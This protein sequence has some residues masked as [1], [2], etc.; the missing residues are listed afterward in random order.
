VSHR[1]KNPR[2]N[3]VEAV[4]ASKSDEWGDATRQ[5]VRSDANRIL[6]ALVS[7]IGIQGVVD[8]MDRQGF[9]GAAYRYLIAPL[10]EEAA[11][12]RPPREKGQHLLN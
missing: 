12:R 8:A 11:S 7:D 6:E 2:K 1:H 4:I 5:T 9:E 3:I 10:Y